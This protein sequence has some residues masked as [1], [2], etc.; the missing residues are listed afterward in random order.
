MRSSAFGGIDGRGGARD[1]FGLVGSLPLGHIDHRQV[2]LREDDPDDKDFNIEMLFSSL[3]LGV[4]ALWLPLD[5]H[6]QVR[7]DQS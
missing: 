1:L 6:L 3:C 7:E 5:R 2:M 4:A